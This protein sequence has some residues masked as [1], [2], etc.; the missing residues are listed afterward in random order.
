M[1]EHLVLL[2]RKCWNYYIVPAIAISLVSGAVV[3]W[4]SREHVT[5]AS[6]RTPKN[7]ENSNWI[8]S[9]L[10]KLPSFRKNRPRK[11][12]EPGFQYM[13]GLIASQLTLSYRATLSSGHPP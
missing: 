3:Y 6:I 12:P 4:H 8:G 1:K 9:E 13:E 11:A 5:A 10:I 7:I 2:T